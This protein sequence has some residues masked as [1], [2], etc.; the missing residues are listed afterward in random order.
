MQ[1]AADNMQISKRLQLVLHAAH[2]MPV[3]GVQSGRTPP[4]MCQL[5]TI[6]THTQNDPAQHVRAGLKA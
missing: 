4:V 2:V 1:T 3:C 5:L 6:T